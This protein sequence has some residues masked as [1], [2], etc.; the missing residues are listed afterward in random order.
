MVE[1][2]EIPYEEKYSIVLDFTKFVEGFVLPLVEKDLGAQKVSELRSIWQNETQTIREDMSYE[3]KYEIA[4]GNWVRK[5]T[6]AFN[7]VRDN[8]GDKGIEEFKYTDLEALKRKTSGPALYLLKLVRALSPQT[9]FRAFAKQMA[10]LYQ[11]FGP[12]TVSELSGSKLVMNLHPCKL[13]NYA[14]SEVLCPVCQ[15]VNSRAMQDQFGVKVAM[16]PQGNNCTMTMSP[17][18]FRALKSIR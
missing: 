15:Y 8:L 7:F 9:A 4:F 18:E 11:A 5:E 14:G 10:Y 16:N 13:L 12:L 17:I 1:I 3:E 2:K 6:S